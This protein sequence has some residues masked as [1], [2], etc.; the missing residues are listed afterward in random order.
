MGQW[1]AGVVLAVTNQRQ[2]EDL[3]TVEGQSCID[4]RME[5]EGKSQLGVAVSFIFKPVVIKK[6]P[7]AP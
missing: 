7:G 4:S 1:E 3:E 5:T 2:L 6:C